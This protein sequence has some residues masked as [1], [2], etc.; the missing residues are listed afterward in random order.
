MPKPVMGAILIFVTCYMITAGIQILMTIDFDVQKIFI[1]GASI[2]FGLSA[3]ILPDLYNYVPGG[4]KAIFSSSLTF[5]TVLA[6][7]FTQM[8][9][10][11]DYIKG[12]ISKW[13]D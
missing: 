9:K 6:I 5:S 8:F 4:L 2:I 1:I 3:D 13:E 11:G 7:L 10:L 12:M